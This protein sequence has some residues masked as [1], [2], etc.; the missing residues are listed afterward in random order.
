MSTYA[1]GIVRQQLIRASAPYVETFHYY[2]LVSEF[3]RSDNFCSARLIS[4]CLCCLSSW[5]CCLVSCL[6][7]S[8]SCFRLSRCF[9]HSCFCFSHACFWLSSCCLRRSRSSSYFCSWLPPCCCKTVVVVTPVFL[10]PTV[11]FNGGISCELDVCDSASVSTVDWITGSGKS[12]IASQILFKW[13]GPK[14][15]YSFQMKL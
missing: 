11:L 13:I 9:S 7:V 3:G 10:E 6:C 12:V 5:F 14:W 15:S 8:H 1:E 2:F 4:S